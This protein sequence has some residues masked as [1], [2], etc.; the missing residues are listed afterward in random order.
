MSNLQLTN[1]SPAVKTGR[2]SNG[3]AVT[4]C[5]LRYLARIFPPAS[6]KTC[7]LWMRGPSRSETPAITASESCFAI[8]WSRGTAAALAGLADVAEVHGVRIRRG[9]LFQPVLEFHVLVVA[10]EGDL[11]L[12]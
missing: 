2:S 12:G 10:V 7:P 6:M 1:A 3:A 5:V 11:D 8:F 9:D 4:K